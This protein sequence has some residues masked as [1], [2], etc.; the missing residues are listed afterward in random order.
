MITIALDTVIH[1]N[2]EILLLRFPFDNE[3]INI[4]KKLNDVRWSATH[5][6]WYAAHTPESLK[7]IKQIFTGIA[8]I[9]DSVIARK[10][11]QKI[12]PTTIQIHELSEYAKNKIT[13]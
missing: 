3:L 9:D 1:R 4:A 10:A 6:A 7:Q 5:K 2:K 13:I 8:N 12:N 11:I